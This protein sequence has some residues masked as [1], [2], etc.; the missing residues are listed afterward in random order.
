MLD[1]FSKELKAAREKSGISLQQ[2]AQKSR[3]DLKFI[4]A[5]DRGDFGFLPELYVRAFIKQYAKIVGLDEQDTINKYEAARKGKTIE[6]QETD[7]NTESPIIKSASTE[8]KPKPESTAPVRSFQENFQK[9]TETEPANFLER[10]KKDKVLLS[11]VISGVV[12]VLFIII[13]FFFI[14]SGSDIIVAE[15]PYDQIMKENQERYLKENKTAMR[16][17][18]NV[19]ASVDSM[20][21][22]IQATDTSWFH[23]RIDNSEIMEF[24]LFPNA[25]KTIKAGTTFNMTIGNAGDT[26]LMLD[27]KSLDL[28]G[29][30][31]QVKNV[32]IDKSGLKYLESPPTFGQ[33]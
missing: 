23:I 33:K 17:K 30:I 26:R 25:K 22:V 29:N 24:V 18:K 9:T 27:G 28:A 31:K 16:E 19:I 6:K 3:I 10:L 1:K 2:I 13:Y 12:A 7:S 20:T 5:L 8:E 14:K 15:K 32:S 21:L 11:A 4:E